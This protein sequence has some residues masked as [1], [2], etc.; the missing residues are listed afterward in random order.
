MFKRI[1]IMLGM[2]ALMVI[3]AQAGAAQTMTGNVPVQVSGWFSVLWGD[4]IDGTQGSVQ[5]Y[6][7]TT[8]EGERIQLLLDETN[9]D[10]LSLNQ[11][12]IQATGV[13]VQAEDPSQ[14]AL[15]RVDSAML[16]TQPENEVS[17]AGVSGS[18]PWVSI[19]CKFADVEDE[20]RD[21][22]Y[23]LQMFSS[24]YPGLDHFWREQSYG[25]VNLEG[26]SAV[27]WVE[28]PYPRDY[29]VPPVGFM[30]LYPALV[31]C[32]SAADAYVDYTQYIGI[33]MMFNG[34]LD[35]YAWGGG[36][37]ICLDG[38][39][40]FWSLTWEPPGGFKNIGVIEHETG[41]GF[42]LPHSSGDYG[43]TYDN[44][45]DVMSDL[46]SN[47]AR[48]AVDPV[49]GGMGQH[50][51][52]FHK[53]LLGWI[54]NS[55]ITTVPVGTHRTLTLERVAL[56]QSQN[57]M[58]VIVP[59]DEY[60][61]RYLTIEARQQVGYDFWLPA[62]EGWNQSVILHEVDLTLENLAHVIDIDGNGN[63]GDEGAMWLPGETYHDPQTGIR[64]TVNYATP[65]GFVV[66]VNNRY[67]PPGFRGPE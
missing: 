14:P 53:A 67:D 8:A 39:C 2:F 46:W 7:L 60:P 50:T 48:G 37:T 57:I 26:S 6:Y 66:T 5:F 17:E 34:N 49:Y 54:G 36:S 64:I 51:I 1:S 19:L 32:T 43:L 11:Q 55:Q 10:W 12:Y 62:V 35:G 65:T 16:E 28:L 61:Y 45:W 33:N 47:V 22:D 58:L 4:G 38:E 30:D 18:K 31:D 63:T 13:W 42:G 59:I 44:A 3:V 23:F 15:F 25:Q 40:R 52:A 21:L 29:Y 24:E 20:P 9:L 41:H 56:P 27:D